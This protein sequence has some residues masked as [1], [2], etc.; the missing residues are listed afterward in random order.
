M[1]RLQII[2]NGNAYPRL[3]KPCRVLVWQ[4]DKRVEKEFFLGHIKTSDY[5]GRYLVPRESAKA[6]NNDAIEEIKRMV[7]K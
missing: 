1:T 4:P 2:L 5:S 6:A 7:M 3:A